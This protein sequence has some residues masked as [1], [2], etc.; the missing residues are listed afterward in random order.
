MNLMNYA[1]VIEHLKKKRRKKHL[2]LGN[3]FSMAFSADMFSYNAFSDF[4]AKTDDLLL[5]KMFEIVNTR[6]FE[7]IM[8]QLDVF[9]R[10]ALEFEADDCFVNKISSTSSNLKKRL[11]D[12][13][14]ELH[15]E[16]VFKIPEDKSRNS[17]NFFKEYLDGSDLEGNIFSANYDLL[18]YWVLMSNQSI[19]TD[20]VDGFGRERIDDETPGEEP[21]YGELEWGPNKILQKIHY[22]HG[23]LH[24]FDT[25]VAVI[26]E[27]YDGNY[28]LEK[29]QS[30]I[31]KK[32][33]PIFVTAGDGKQKLEQILHN[34]YLDYCYQ[35]LCLI[36]GSLVTFGFN[37]GDYD[38]HIIDAI[39]K[40]AKQ[41][42][43]SGRL[44]SVYIGVYS[45]D[46]VKHMKSI[47]SMFKC[48]KIHLFDAKTANVWG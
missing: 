6:N 1:D 36:K 39:N 24:L 41:P 16:H 32:E 19:I 4:V 45:D 42:K 28:L 29:I 13:I 21:E 25:G 48:Q 38:H 47:E 15:P 12:A 44:W 34:P 5:K 30:R 9:Q 27:I 26:K 7:V 8:S 31:E 10:L 46:D 23:A 40:A 17:A 18:L 37:F 14:S 35:K 43:K 22:V 11:I 2:F 33:Y 3:G 20:S